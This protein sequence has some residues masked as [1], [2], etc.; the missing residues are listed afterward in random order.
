M[1]NAPAPGGSNYGPPL[2]QPRNQGWGSSSDWDVTTHVAGSS[3]HHPTVT[4]P[5]VVPP[6]VDPRADSALSDY[7]RAD[8]NR[9]DPAPADTAQ[10]RR[11]TRE[12][13][14]PGW[15]AVLILIAIAGAGGLFDLA[16][17][18]AVKGGFNIA[19]VIAAVVAILVVR[20]RGMFA[21][22][23]APPLVYFIASAGMLYVRS[24]GL[25]DRSRMLDSAINWLVYGF[26]AIAGA[27]AAVLI[28]AG[29]RMVVRR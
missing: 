7:T 8:L 29:I 16:R 17:G 28:I 20:R 15:V 5:G 3:A 24:N 2:S 21:V 23:V 12:R 19:L 14:L 11:A 22:V 25:H 6:R 18:S 4:T 1:V 9:A 10:P 26:P 13:G 27:T